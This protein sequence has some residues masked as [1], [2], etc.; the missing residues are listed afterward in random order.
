MC[1]GVGCWK[2]CYICNLYIRHVRYVDPRDL[3]RLFTLWGVYPANMIIMELSL[4]Q[5]SFT[6]SLWVKFDITVLG[7]ID[8]RPFQ[9]EDLLEVVIATL[10]EGLVV[11]G[12]QD[13]W[14]SNGF[15][16]LHWK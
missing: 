11:I 2:F 1:H 9:G 12:V 13:Q 14:F 8:L 10:N 15:A 3:L 4:E 7:E 16:V 5:M 6:G